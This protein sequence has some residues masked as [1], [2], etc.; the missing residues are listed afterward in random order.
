MPDYSKE[1]SAIELKGTRNEI[2]RTITDNREA[3]EFFLKT[4]PNVMM[5]V[6]L[7]NETKIKKLYISE[8]IS[9]TIPQ[10]VMGSLGKSVKVVVKKC[11]RGRPQ[12][13]D[14]KKI[15][16]VLSKKTSNKEKMEE[17]GM[18][19]RTFFYWKKKLGFGKK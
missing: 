3:E 2:Y 6:V 11:R 7:L 14:E 9:R 4:K 16:K 17:L 19:R 1:P 12:K 8:G 13:Y 5:F 15:R 18:P 10:K